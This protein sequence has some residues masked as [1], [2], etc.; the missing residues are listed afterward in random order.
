[1]SLS[2]PDHLSSYFHENQKDWFET[3]LTKLEPPQQDILFKVI[4]TNSS[5]Y[6]VDL[7]EIGES[8]EIKVLGNLK[9][10]LTRESYIITFDKSQGDFKCNCKDFKFRCSA[11]GLLCKHISFVVCKVLNIFDINFFST[12]RMTPSQ[13]TWICKKI[14]ENHIWKDRDLSIKYINSEFKEKH[15]E[16]HKEDSCPICLKSFEEECVLSCPNCNQYVHR[17]CMKVW[18]EYNDTCVFCRSMKWQD[19]I[20]NI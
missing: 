9:K 8:I 5:I 20:L 2:E 7:C 6:L 14:K 4:N 19:Y 3:F 17:D 16:F 1:M 13:T 15:R 18:L 10:D 11:K 12:K